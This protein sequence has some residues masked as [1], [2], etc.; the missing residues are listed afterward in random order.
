MARASKFADRPHARIYTAWT[1][2][3][4]WR[5]LSGPAVKLL[6]GLLAEFRPGRDRNG[7]IPISAERAGDL[8][9]ASPAT[10]RRAR[11]ELEAAGLLRRHEPGRFRRDQPATFAITVYPDE[12][13]GVLAS[14]PFSD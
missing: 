7:A 2:S 14:C 6:V 1:R 12:V 10:G 13:T 8:I 9:G 11:D 5:G 3:P 4:L